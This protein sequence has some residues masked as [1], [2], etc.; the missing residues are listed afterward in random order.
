MSYYAHTHE[1]GEW[2]TVKEHL[3]GT[4][5]KAR[6]FAIPQ[7][8]ESAFLLGLLHDMGKYSDQFQ[9][10]LSG[11]SIHVDHSTYGAKEVL[12]HSV[13]HFT[14]FFLPMRWRDITADC[15]I[16]ETKA[17]MRTKRRCAQE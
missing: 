16:T 15:R 8:K 12:R 13:K 4:A 2:Q 14:E 10:K 6:S 3:L 11:K 9:Q 17:S 5:D 7:L 1:N